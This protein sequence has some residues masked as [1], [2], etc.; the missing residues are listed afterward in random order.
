[1]NGVLVVDKPP[2]MT[3]HDVVARVKQRLEAAKVGHLGTL[4]PAATGVLPLV[5]N[6]ATKFARWLEMGSKEYAAEMTL[7][8]ETD[9]YDSEGKVI[10]EAPTHGITARDIKRVF[11]GLKGRILQVP[12]MFSA[13]KISGRPLYK[14]AR[15][16]RTVERPAREVEI[17]SLE[18]T[19]FT[20]PVVSF[21]VSCAR[22][23][24]VRSICHDAGQA[25]GCGAYMS[26]LRRLKSGAFQLGEA[27]D[28]AADK[29]EMLGALIPLE[30]A[31]LRSVSSLRAVSLDGRALFIDGAG[32][33]ITISGGIDLATGM[34]LVFSQDKGFPPF[35]E[36]GEMI[37]LTLAG[38]DLALAIR[39]AGDLCKIKWVFGGHLNG[40]L[41]RAL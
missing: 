41:R 35:L 13:V 38:R 12:P 9:S 34:R 15:K 37:R 20:L 25:L 27:I 36:D 18:I 26:K 17:F 30:E 3:S 28:A 2:G 24:Y 21:T 19:G 29:A 8:V 33:E 23:T 1:M 22:G 10:S 5:I 4:D 11:S 14:L 31:L 16:G 32:E 6:R 7:G 39:L 40:G